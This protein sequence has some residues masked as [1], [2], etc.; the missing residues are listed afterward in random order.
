MASLEFVVK[1]GEQQLIQ[2]E[3]P[4]P[5]ETKY[6]SNIDDQAGLR[7]HIPFVHFY[8]GR[9]RDRCDPAPIICRALSRTLVHYYPLAG[10]IRNTE[11]GKLV[12]E[13]TGEGVVFREADADVTIEQLQ[14]QLG[15]LGLVPPFPR[16]DRLLVDDIWGCF[17]ITDSPLLRMQV[18]RLACGGFV[19]AYTFNHCMCDAA[20]ALQFLTAVAESARD[21]SINS[22]SLHPVWSR[23]ALSPRSPPR[24]S[25]PHYEYDD[26]I[27]NLKPG[28]MYSPSRFRRLAQA[29]LFLP[30]EAVST[31]KH[32]AAA[33]ASFDAVAACLWRA[34]AR[35][36]GL[37]GRDPAYFLFPV[38]TRSRGTPRLP[39]GYYGAAVVF[40]CA[41]ALTFDLC[42]KPLRY[43]SSKVATAKQI[44]LEDE[45]WA[46][47]VDFLE[48]KGGNVGFRGGEG[49][50][51]VSDQSLPM[52]TW[53]GAGQC[54][55]VR[56]G[57][58][59]GQSLGWWQRWRRTVGGWRGGLL[60]I[61]SIP[62]E[63]MEAFKR[64]VW[65][66]IEGTSEE[67]VESEKPLRSAL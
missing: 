45:Y 7:N 65:G 1:V 11:K 9:A 6:L 39:R 29:S 19:L 32:R 21:P 54:M 18:T 30:R 60:A 13:C 25:F 51:V 8:R 59:L 24:I 4:T 46:S 47:V 41:T 63:A 10:R 27:T 44:A 20:G 35:A 5:Y 40:P 33:A 67:E 3:T 31:L 37:S 57:R 38:Y 64:E 56:G 15:G 34:R 22:L 28:P 2:P 36:L 66:M 17:L 26:S 23:E 61:F 16:W 48:G 50:F 14:R 55:A 43:A 58:G 49:V 42:R 53:V 52:S 62:D 12:V